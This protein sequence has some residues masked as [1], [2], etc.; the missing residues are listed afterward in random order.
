MEA[1]ISASRLQT[2]DKILSI[3]NPDKQL[4][5]YY[6][7]KRLCAAIY[8][9]MQA[10]EVT[11]RNALNEAVKAHGIAPYLGQDWWFE[12]IS[13]HVQNKKINKMSA[14]NKQKWLKPDGSR[15]KLGYQEAAIKK[16]IRDLN[17]EDRYPI[18]HEDVL[19]R[20]MFGFWLAF[21]HKD[22][23][24]STNKSL[25]WPNLLSVV[26]PNY[27]GKVKLSKVSARLQWI[28][29]L[30]NRMSH[31]E[32]VWKFYKYKPNGSVDYSKPVYGLNASISILEKQYNEILETIR[33]MSQERYDSFIHAGLDA[34]FRKLCS[35]N[36]FNAFVKPDL[37]TP[38]IP[39]S[40]AKR[41]ARKILEDS[42]NGQLT[43]I[44]RAGKTYAI[45]GVNG[46]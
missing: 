35:I 12:H 40:R 14:H 10:L 20:S 17:K 23:E 32:P 38:N 2:Y 5:A 45:I 37:V 43:R 27:P 1:F 42:R 31:H 13:T 6:W 30:R 3:S 19:S 28:K 46:Y 22:Y 34:E 26:F 41:E 24:D 39:R 9:V 33:W 7:N 18:H 8:P 16:V 21:I 25:L 4:K 11:L 15:K 44:T 36:G 29:D